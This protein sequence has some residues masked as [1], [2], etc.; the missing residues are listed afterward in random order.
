MSG[1][2]I[3]QNMNNQS[4]QTIATIETRQSAFKRFIMRFL[5]FSKKTQKKEARVDQF[6]ASQREL[7]EKIFN[8][9]PLGS[10]FE[11][12]GVTCRVNRHQTYEMILLSTG[13]FMPDTTPQVDCEYVDKKGQI[14]EISFR[15]QELEAL[16]DA[17]QGAVAK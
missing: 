17:E 6:F 15:L 5:P 3:L 9:Y 1:N 11:Y 16:L 2:L 8:A 14:H 13:R 4:P 10:E 7:E 12:M